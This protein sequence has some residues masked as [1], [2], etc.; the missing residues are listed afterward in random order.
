M[1]TMYYDKDADLSLIQGRK[2]GVIGYGSQGHAHALNLKDS[3]VKVRV[4]LP[5]GS[6]SVAKAQAAGLEVADVASVAA[7][8]EARARYEVVSNR[9]PALSASTGAAEEGASAS[10]LIANVTERVSAPRVP[11]T[12]TL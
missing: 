11:V 10:T 6:R 7:G 3:G 9:D 8:H 1:A 5:P 4:G 2:V 12:R